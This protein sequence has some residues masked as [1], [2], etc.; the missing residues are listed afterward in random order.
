MGE[1]IRAIALD[2]GRV[3]STLSREMQR[4]SLD[5]GYCDVKAARLASARRKAQSPRPAIGHAMRLAIQSLLVLRQWSPEQIVES[6]RGWGV[7]DVP[8]PATIY[9]HIHQ[10]KFRGGH[11]QKHL[12]QG[13]RRRRRSADE[14]PG[15][16]PDRVGI[17]KRPAVVDA[18]ARI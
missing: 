7:A 12:R 4:N 5:G 16:I 10:D 8:C 2:L 11:L 13:G 17:E 6:L 1:S 15:I 14:Y 3:A 18:H 9:K